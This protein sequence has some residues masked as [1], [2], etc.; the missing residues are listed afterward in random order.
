MQRDYL[1]V[2]ASNLGMAVGVKLERRRWIQ[3]MLSRWSLSAEFVRQG[4]R[5]NPK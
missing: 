4:R 3:G 5:R 2:S 1:G